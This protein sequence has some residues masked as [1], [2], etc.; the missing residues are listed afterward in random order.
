RAGVEILK[1]GG[2][3]AD[4]AATIMLVLGVVSPSSSDA[5]FTGPPCNA[6]QNFWA[7]RNC[8]RANGPIENGPV[9]FLKLRCSTTAC[10]GNIF[11]FGRSGFSRRIVSGKRLERRHG[12]NQ[13][14]T[15]SSA[16]I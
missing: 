13:S 10:I 3:A 5:V 16:V 11:Q 9:C 7:P 14:G 4:A 2:T 8:L 12:H 1:R 6:P 15:R